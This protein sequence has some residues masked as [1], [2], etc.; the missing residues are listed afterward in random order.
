MLHRTVAR[1]R[2]VGKVSH[3]MEKATPSVDEKHLARM[4]TLIAAVFSQKKKGNSGSLL[5]AVV[6]LKRQT[7]KV[8]Q[9][10]QLG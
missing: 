4:G 9:S 1:M 8:F 2:A 5:F 7:T 6:L 3:C 10:P